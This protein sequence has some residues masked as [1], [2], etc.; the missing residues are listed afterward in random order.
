MDIQRFLA[1][2]ILFV[3]ATSLSAQQGQ[4]QQPQE[5]QAQQ[6]Q[7][8]DAFSEDEESELAEDTVEIDRDDLKKYAK[9]Y[10]AV[11]DIRR[12]YAEKT[13]DADSSEQASQIHREGQKARI[14]AIKDAGLTV[15]R[16]NE[17]QYATR[18]SPATYE[19][20]SELLSR[21]RTDREA[22]RD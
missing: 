18:A 4:S 20:F 8:L 15:E 9:A 11:S 5:P 19:K 12:D 2:L 17:I 16:F 1:L 7:E 3:L 10:E 6:Q 22:Q 14:E 13:Q 21:H